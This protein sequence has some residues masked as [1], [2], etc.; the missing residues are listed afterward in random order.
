MVTTVVL[1]ISGSTV[2]LAVRVLLQLAAPFSGPFN[3]MP[4]PLAPPICLSTCPTHLP[5]PLVPPTWPTHLLEPVKVQHIGNGLHCAS[6]LLHNIL[7]FLQL[8]VAVFLALGPRALHSFQLG[9][10]GEGESEGVG[11][12]TPATTMPGV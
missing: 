10:R 1:H 7:I 3:S 4:H 9:E 2:Y 11:A 12:Y 5:H 8:H 6:V